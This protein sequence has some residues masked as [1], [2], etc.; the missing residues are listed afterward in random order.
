VFELGTIPFAI[1]AV[2]LV[3]YGVYEVLQARYR[4]IHVT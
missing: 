1:V 4:R 3:A 2:G